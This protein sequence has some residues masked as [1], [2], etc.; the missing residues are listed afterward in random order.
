MKVQKQAVQTYHTILCMA[1]S[2]AIQIF[3]LEVYTA[4]SRFYTNMFKMKKS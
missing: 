3:F 4:V 2:Y 1:F